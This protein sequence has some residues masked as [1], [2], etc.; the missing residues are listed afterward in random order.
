MIARK[1]W[2]EVRG[3]TVAYTLLLELLLIP[4]ILLWPDLRR[5][6]AGIG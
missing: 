2:R 5:A 3:M 1:T 4:A 6:G